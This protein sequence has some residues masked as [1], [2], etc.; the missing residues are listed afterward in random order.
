MPGS[1]AASKP[2]FE[3]FFDELY[4]ETYRPFEDEERNEREARFIVEAM[5]LHPG[6]LV[7]DLGCG[8]GRHAV[9]LA[10]WGYRVVCYDLSDYL[11]EK[12]RER[13]EEFSVVGRVVLVKG[14]M[15]SLSYDAYFD[16]AYMFFTTFGYFT[17]TENLEVVKRVAK[18]LKPGGVFLV[19]VW[20]PVRVIHYAHVHEGRRA[21]WYEVGDYVVIEES[22]YDVFNARVEVKRV[23]LKKSL[24]RV[25]AERRFSIRFYMPWELRGLLEEAGLVTEKTY[26]SYT[27]EEYRVTS[28]RLI[29][30]ARRKS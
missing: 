24:G 7:L 15:R 17:D 26:G 9:Y 27:G 19:D 13:V 1:E 16:G 25:V 8:Y 20:N 10:R 28:P 22:R 12:A 5:G 2:W 21:S 23:F 3:T 30:V 14:D 11:L 18:A 4:Y 6:S 29:V